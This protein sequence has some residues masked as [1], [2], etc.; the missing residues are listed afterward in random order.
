MSKKIPVQFDTLPQ[1]QSV[2]NLLQAAIKALPLLQGIER[3][4]LE[5]A[6]RQFETTLVPTA[7]RP[8]DFEGYLQGCDKD[9][10]LAAMVIF[11]EG[12]EISDVDWARIES[13]CDQYMRA[14]AEEHA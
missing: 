12:Y 11:Q 4:Q 6:I 13:A 14:R 1:T 9:D 5:A 3:Q 2:E 10:V 7:W 8:A